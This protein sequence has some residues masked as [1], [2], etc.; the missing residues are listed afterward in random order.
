M[1]TEASDDSSNLLIEKEK[2]Y[3]SS[4]KFESGGSYRDTQGIEVKIKKSSVCRL[5]ECSFRIIG[6]KGRDGI[7]VFKPKNLAQN[8]DPSTDISGHPSFRQL[9]P[10]KVQVVKDMTQAGIPPRQILSSLRKQIPNLPATSRTVYNVKRQIQ[11]ETLGNCSEV[12]ALFEQLQKGGFFF[13]YDVLHNSEGLIT[14]L[15]VAHPLS[16]KLTKVFSNIFVMDYTYKTNK[17]NMPLLDIVGVSCFNSSFYSG[18]SFL[19]REDEENYTWAL[20]VFNDIIGHENHPLVIMTDRELALMNAISNVFPSTTN[21]LC[22][23][24]I[25]K[26]VVANCKKYFGH[27][28]DF[29]LF[30]LSW[31]NV[32]YST[33]EAIFLNNWAEFEFTY[34]NKKDAIEYIRNIWLPWKEKFVSPW[35]EI[36]LHFRNRASSR[37]K[38]AHSKLKMYLQNSTGGFQMVKEKICLAVE[39]EF[40]EIKVKVASQKIQVPNYCNNPVYRDLLYRVSQFALKEISN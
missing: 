10:N 32:V 1:N 33:T 26:N 16:N 40:N 27:A 24:H 25:E 17:Y 11:K 39:H 13:F 37:A 18:F 6:S 12:G 9:S 19:D 5:I 31:K 36:F 7:W 15:F 8:H 23:W 21:L 34:T 14:R 35:T 29:D 4:S 28:E 38:G 2:I 20:N 22:V 3:L 30:M